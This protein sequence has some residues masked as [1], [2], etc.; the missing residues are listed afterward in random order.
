MY[1]RKTDFY[2]YQFYYEDIL[3]VKRGY[4]NVDFRHLLAPRVPLNGGF[5]PIF[6]GIEQIEFLL[7]Q[8]EEDTKENLRPYLEQ[9]ERQK[10]I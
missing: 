9:L 8:G 3:R 5:V 1:S 6:D 7:K 4:P 2:D 10:K